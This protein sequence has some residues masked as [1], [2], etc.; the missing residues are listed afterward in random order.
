M[1]RAQIATTFKAEVLAICARNTI[2]RKFANFV[3]LYF[4]HITT[5]SHQIL[6]FYYFC[7]VLFGN[8]YVWKK[9]PVFRDILQQILNFNGSKSLNYNSSKLTLEFVLVIYFLKMCCQFRLYLLSTES[10]L[11]ISKSM[12]EYIWDTYISKSSCPI[13]CIYYFLN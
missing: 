2:M 5:F 12:H 7:K 13:K 10:E 4:P 9:I 6:G 11:G 8:V 3:R 1:L